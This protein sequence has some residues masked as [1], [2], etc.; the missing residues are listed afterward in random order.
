MN[1]SDCDYVLP[2]ALVAQEPLAEREA[3]RLLV[4]DRDTGAL[5]HRA[6]SEL[7]S[8]LR[9]GDLVVLN[10]TRVLPARLVG[11]KPS[12]GKIELLLVSD[13]EPK[14]GS[15]VWRCLIASSRPPKAGVAFALG[16][17]FFGEVLERA[18]E[19]WRVRLTDV[20]GDPRARIESLGVMP[21]PPYIRRAPEDP[22][23][24]RDRER[25]QTV[26]ARHTGSIAAPTAGLHFTTRLLREMEASGARL[27]WLTL[28]I[29]LGT[30]QP[31]RVALVE[32]HRMHREAF[33]LPESTAAAVEETRRAGGRVVAVGTTVVRVLESRARATGAVT[34]GSGWCD[35]F[36]LPGYRF[37]VVDA[38][39]TN[40]HLPRSTL[41]LLL[42]AFAGRER[43]LAAYEEAIRRSYRF[44]SYGDA[45]FVRSG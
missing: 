5:E 42:C 26:F 16:E 33:E 27:G 35:L 38:L 30:F 11:R 41:L 25:Y 31:I 21:V 29:G 32:E 7:P 40:F 24:L 20:S 43:V 28:H 8:F 15:G 9:P 3:S 34:P 37:R 12:G 6:F 2:Q 1:L 13:D 14:G 39:V 10:D 45:M 4:L 19:T 17:G 36:I 18:G 44:Y 22:R 23:L